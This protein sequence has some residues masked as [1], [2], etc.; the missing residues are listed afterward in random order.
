MP[1]KG[2]ESINLL[3]DER[4]LRVKKILESRHKWALAFSGGKDSTTL[5][6]FASH[7]T[8][9]EVIPV[10]L[11]HDLLPSSEKERVLSV[12][13]TLNLSDRLINLRCSVLESSEVLV[14]PTNRCYHCKRILMGKLA[15][16][17]NSLGCDG[18]CDGTV[19]DDQESGRSGI[20][21]L[22]E[23]NVISPL[24]RGG[25]GTQEV[26]QLVEQ[27][28]NLPPELIRPESCLATRLP[29]GTKL[30]KGLLQK[31]DQ[32]E[33]FIKSLCRGPVRA[34]YHP[35]DNMVRIE[36]DVAELAAII[37]GNNRIDLSRLATKLG[38]R[39]LTLDLS[40]FRSGSWDR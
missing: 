32:L 8:T 18:L 28:I 40:G 33:G 39:F 16:L 1:P 10:F 6:W 36:L 22:R 25:I 19:A 5:L 13:K 23:Y 27:V 7:F 9:V 20:R 12:L 4:W 37:E 2:T 21:A 15:E 11:E 3:Q 26:V 17:A 31:L 35:S 38:F 34:R 24:A 30:D 29:Y 14:N